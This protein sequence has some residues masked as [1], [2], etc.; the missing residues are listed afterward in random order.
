MAAATVLV[1]NSR[2]CCP[3]SHRRRDLQFLA[4]LGALDAAS[5][6]IAD[7]AGCAVLA[8]AD[9]RRAGVGGSKVE[10]AENEVEKLVKVDVT[11][12][13]CLIPSRPVCDEHCD[14]A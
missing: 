5:R 8:E 14:E 9:R 4:R 6:P 2:H 7:R 3:V 12:P 11:I 10:L 13:R 1:R